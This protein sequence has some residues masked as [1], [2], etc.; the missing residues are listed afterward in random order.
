MITLVVVYMLLSSLFPHDAEALMGLREGAAAGVHCRANVR[1]P[2]SSGGIT[3][4]SYVDSRARFGTRRD[5]FKH[6]KHRAA[7]AQ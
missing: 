2:V 4:G 3:L 6:I 1:A 5:I 7:Q